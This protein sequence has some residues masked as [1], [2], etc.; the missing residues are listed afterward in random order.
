MA[1][2]KVKSRYQV[3]IPTGV[4][5]AARLKV[6]DVLEASISGKGILLRP[7]SLVARRLDE[8]ERDVKAGRVL[9]PFTSARAATRALKRRARAGPPR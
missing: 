5:T 2:T 9:G 8:A 1:L 6:G 7:K 4:R 3:T